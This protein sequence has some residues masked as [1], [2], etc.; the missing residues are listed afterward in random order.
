[1]YDGVVTTRGLVDSFENF[2]G[3]IASI[4]RIDEMLLWKADK[5]LPDYT[6]S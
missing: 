1:L 6:A 2:E 3:N 5:Q 4:F